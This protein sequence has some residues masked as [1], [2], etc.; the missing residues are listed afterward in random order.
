MDVDV[1]AVDD[2]DEEDYQVMGRMT[3]KAQ[4]EAF[5]QVMQKQPQCGR[6]RG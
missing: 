6:R 1:D 2:V 3:M 4:S 5:F